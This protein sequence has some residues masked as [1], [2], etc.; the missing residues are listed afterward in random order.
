MNSFGEV[1]RVSI[2]GESHGNSIGAV[3]DG[4]PPGIPVTADDFVHDLSRRRSGR[5]GTTKRH[6]PDKPEI[7]SGIFNDHTTGS[8]ITVI[9]RNSDKISSDYDDFRNIPRPGHADFTAGIKYS[10]FSDMRGSG[11]F[12]GRITWGLVAAGVI[13]K[14]ILQPAEI[15]ARLISAGGNP[16]IESAIEKAVLENDSIGGIIECKV[17]NPRKAIG[18][19]FFYSVESA[20]SHIVFSIPAIKGVEFG[21]GFSAASMKGS[22]HND[23]IID[24]T[25]RTLT[26]NAGGINGGITNGN[27]IL[28]RVAVKPTSSTGAEQRTY[29][30]S[31]GQLTA[32]KVKGRHDTCIA[33]RIPVIVEAAAAIALADLLLLDRGIHGSRSL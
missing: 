11:H 14:K 17:T 28:F 5:T 1:F 15:S 13:A 23:P 12:S 16:D 8:P 18:E 27:E 33:L 10:G 24:G 22:V 6:E 26:N 32:L 3:I 2:F 19:P 9:T 21:S 7:L 31:T 30:F 29:D 4:C 20:I 25:G